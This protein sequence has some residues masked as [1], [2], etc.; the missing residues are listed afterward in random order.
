MERPQLAT[1]FLS[2][3]HI[4]KVQTYAVHRWSLDDGMKSSPRVF[5]AILLLTL[6]LKMIEYTVGA[7]FITRFFLGLSIVS[8]KL[9]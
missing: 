6:A 2:L 4:W 3:P 9:R 1:I 8:F 7:D 5:G